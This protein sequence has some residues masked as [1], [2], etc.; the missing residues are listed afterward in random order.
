MNNNTTTLENIKSSQEI[1]KLA[2]IECPIERAMQLIGDKYSVLIV[3]NLALCEKQRFIELE[4]S[5]K[6]ISPRTL[7]ARLKHLEKYGIINRKQF[8]TI[9]PKVEYSLTDRGRE[10]K[11]VIEQISSWVDKWYPHLPCE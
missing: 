3:L 4:Q 6:G 9:P 7:S 1:E 5:I 8:S 2:E 10:F 11:V